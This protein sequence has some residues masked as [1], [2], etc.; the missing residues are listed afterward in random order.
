MVPLKYF[1]IRTVLYKE[2]NRPEVASFS[3]VSWWE[4][5]GEVSESQYNLTSQPASLG[6]QMP[7]V[8]EVSKDC[9]M[10]SFPAL[11]SKNCLPTALYEWLRATFSGY[12]K[13][14]GALGV[15]NK[16]KEERQEA[17]DPWKENDDS[18]RLELYKIEAW[19]LNYSVKYF[20]QTVGFK[21]H[22]M[23]P[24]GVIARGQEERWKFERHRKALGEGFRGRGQNRSNPSFSFRKSPNKFSKLCKSL[25]LIKIF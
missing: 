10:I 3:T 15:P 25:I 13:N 19:K 7:W 14:V 17:Q 16:K 20:R 24:G 12:S 6:K 21:R 8:D 1:R 4:A 9:A 5:K 18:K 2:K 23:L 22:L 11:T